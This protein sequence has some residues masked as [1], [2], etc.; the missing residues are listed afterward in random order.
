MDF[1]LLLGVE[2]EATA[3]DIKR[4]YKRLARKY[5]PDI[6]PGDRLA[7][8]GAGPRPAA[9]VAGSA[10]QPVGVERGGLVRRDARVRLARQRGQPAEACVC[11]RHWQR[12]SGCSSR[13]FLCGFG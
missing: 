13:R 4:A 5:H 7:R 6:N 11:A 1:Y 10:R 9:Q 8:R 12:H 3:A 2:R